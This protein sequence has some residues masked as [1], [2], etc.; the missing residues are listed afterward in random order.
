LECDAASEAEAAFACGAFGVFGLV[1]RALAETHGN[2]FH[3]ALSVLSVFI[4]R[5]NLTTGK[6]QGN[7]ELLHYD[8][9]Q[10]GQRG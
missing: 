4:K 1:G 5:L 9:R 8:L 2:F 10:T 6:P 3:L 7:H